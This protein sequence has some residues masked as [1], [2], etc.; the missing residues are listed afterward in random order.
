MS[1]PDLEELASQCLQRMQSEGQQA[2]EELCSAHPEHAEEIRGMVQQLLKLGFMEEPAPED[3]ARVGDYKILRRLGGGGM[4]VVYLAL[5]ESLGREVALKV[6]RPGFALHGKSKA[7]FRR[8]I[9][10]IS[11]IDH[12]GV[13]TVY[14][15]R[16]IDGVPYLAMRYVEGESL[17]EILRRRRKEREGKKTKKSTSS[18]GQQELNDLLDCAEKAA[19]ALHCAHEAGLVHRDVKPGNIMIDRNGEPVLLDFGL[20]QDADSESAQLTASGD[21]L[22]TP[23]YMSPEQIESKIV[24]R[25]SDI[26]SL[27]TTLYECL[28]LHT[29]FEGP[30]RPAIYGKVLTDPPPDPRKRNRA[31]SKD[32]WIVLSKALEKDPAH[33][34]ATASEFADELRRIQNREPIHSVPPSL[35]VRARRWTQRNRTATALILALAAGLLGSFWFL[36]RSQQAEERATRFLERSLVAEKRLWALATLGD[37]LTIQRSDPELAFK[38]AREAL[39]AGKGA[40]D[41]RV[42]SRIQ[43]LMF[44][45]RPEQHLIEGRAAFNQ[46]LISRSGRFVLCMGMFQPARLFGDDGEPIDLDLPEG[47][48]QNA[49]AAFSPDEKEFAIVDETRHV[50]RY[51]LTVT[52]PRRIWR[53]SRTVGPTVGTVSYRRF[54]DGLRLLVSSTGDEPPYPRDSQGRW[55]LANRAQV[56]RSDGGEPIEIRRDS[57]SQYIFGGWLPDGRIVAAGA[58][59]T[60]EGEW[61][62]ELEGELESA[63]GSE[64]RIQFMKAC[65][66][67][68]DK[69]VTMTLAGELRVYN[70][71]DGSLWWEQDYS[72]ILG[73][74]V[75]SLSISPNGDRILLGSISGRVLL[76]DIASK[77]LLNSRLGL[78]PLRTVM[79]T[80]F[81]PDGEAF[82]IGYWDGRIRIYD[83]NQLPRDEF[84]T[85]RN[86]GVTSL[87][88]GLDGKHLYSGT[89]DGHVRVHD[90]AGYPSIPQ[91]K[92]LVRPNIAVSRNGERVA[93]VDSMATLRI[94][95]TDGGLLDRY[96]NDEGWFHNGDT[97][98]AF[99]PDGQHLVL[100]TVGKPLRFRD[101]SGKDDMR[102]LK[103]PITFG[104]RTT[105]WLD[106]DTILYRRHGDQKMWKWELGA[107][108][109]ELFERETLE[110]LFEKEKRYVER[111]P[112]SSAISRDRKWIVI[113]YW[114]G[115]LRILDRVSEREVWRSTGK[116][117]MVRCVQLSPDSH[118]VLAACEDGYIHIWDWSEGEGEKVLR[119]GPHM[120]GVVSAAFSPDGRQV[121]GGT[122]S[123]WL[124]VWDAHNARLLFGFEASV[125]TVSQ[126][127][128]TKPG[129]LVSSASDGQVRWWYT[130]TDK[131]MEAVESLPIPELNV[132]DVGPYPQL[133]AFLEDRSRQKHRG[134]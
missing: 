70:Q 132:E 116:L 47:R 57:S 63:V 73:G 26:Y 71:K 131:L 37:A 109:A 100:D 86:G 113:G 120:S 22:G 98:V 3:P 41:T 20:V 130:D 103:V 88:F 111:L 2:L 75:G 67:T 6:M 92:G 105:Q 82:A 117:K 23:P 38:I 5:Q 122:K 62:L 112:T 65:F 79:A 89:W 14:E 28:T 49:Y 45:L 107:P 125:G 128:Y 102:I 15:A 96:Q 81:S 94:A 127:L 46:I 51:D 97:Q 64:P 43:E 115:Y 36:R 55:I 34:F 8:E 7:R 77:T 84:F 95:D 74:Q 35:F 76:V 13:C 90:L 114:K 78:V 18:S 12:P 56:W 87:A 29:P 80:A 40:T 1:A 129:R 27:A 21:Q 39:R 54:C 119:I 99:S 10:A 123:G 30:N 17:A 101:L 52:P 32:L 58:L 126:V 133:R 25:R 48:A 42:Q 108:R 44:G 69:I 59:W 61:I 118:R 91:F 72:R 93:I 60:A 106:D 11:A 66:A 33:R 121:A 124:H 85:S 83:D 19:R 134:H 68:G 24:D 50:L 4:G 110:K 31:I 16:E 9:E 53:S 104:T